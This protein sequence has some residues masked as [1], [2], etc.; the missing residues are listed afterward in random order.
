VALIELGLKF[1]AMEERKEKWDKIGVQKLH[2]SSND[3]ILTE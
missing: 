3:C 2:F 1:E